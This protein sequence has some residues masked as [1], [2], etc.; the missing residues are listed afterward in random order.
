VSKGEH[1]WKENGDAKGYQGSPRAI[2]RYLETLEALSFSARKS[3]SPSA[4]KPLNPLVTLSAQQ[5]TWLFFRR[6]ED[7]KQEERETLRQLRQAS[8]HLEA[9]YH[10][11]ETFLQ[12]VADAH[13]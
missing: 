10:L 11:V 2:Y 8:P 13:R 3:G 9:A 6:P 4:T 1:N 7:V 5:V 12:M